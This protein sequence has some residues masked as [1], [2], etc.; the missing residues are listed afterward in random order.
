MRVLNAL[1]SQSSE[2]FLSSANREFLDKVWEL[3]LLYLNKA[4]HAHENNK[5]PSVAQ[6]TW[7]L[8]ASDDSN[9]ARSTLQTD[10]TQFT[11][12]LKEL[13]LETNEIKLLQSKV[14]VLIEMIRC[15]VTNRSLNVTAVEVTMESYQLLIQIAELLLRRNIS[16]EGLVDS[17]VIDL[18]SWVCELSMSIADMPRLGESMAVEQLLHS[19]WL[20]V[21][22]WILMGRGD[23]DLNRMHAL[24]VLT[25]CLF[26]SC[27][28]LLLKVLN[29]EVSKSEDHSEGGTEGG[30]WLHYVACHKGV[31]SETVRD[32]L[33]RK[34]LEEGCDWTITNSKGKLFYEVGDRD[35]EEYWRKFIVHR[36]SAQASVSKWLSEHSLADIFTAS[37]SQ[38]HDSDSKVSLNQ[39]LHRKSVGGHKKGKKKHK[40]KVK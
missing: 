40:S 10:G 30:T 15:R 32:K 13:L 9:V 7:S 14:S 16:N 6:N 24:D 38:Q 25:T 18:L 26:P 37:R 36:K 11:S 33:M 39:N 21:I 34:L 12:L 35:D 23:I 20:S 5:A 29:R 31:M 22:D 27:R 28:A 19:L 2:G 4:S 3:M 8:C 1:D 17:Q